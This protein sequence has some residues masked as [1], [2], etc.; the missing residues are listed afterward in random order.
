M[1]VLFQDLSRKKKPVGEALP[2]RVRW[3]FKFQDRILSAWRHRLP[4]NSPVCQ[5]ASPAACPFAGQASR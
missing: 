4:P 2:R 1:W 5:P 3:F